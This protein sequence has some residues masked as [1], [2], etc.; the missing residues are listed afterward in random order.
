MTRQELGPYICEER[1]CRRCRAAGG[2]PSGS[3]G[4]RNGPGPDPCRL[5]RED[6]APR[7]GLRRLP[8]G[9]RGS[10]ASSELKFFPS[11][12]SAPQGIDKGLIFWYN[13]NKEPMRNEED[14]YEYT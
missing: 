4:G 13:I 9:S 11:P 8:T 2:C 1:T 7:A 12:F 10:P 14:A 6:P 5:R 3:V